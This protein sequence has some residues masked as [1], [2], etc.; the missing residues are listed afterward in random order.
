MRLVLL[1]LILCT[2][3]KVGPAYHPPSVETPESW[4]T[5][6]AALAPIPPLGEWWDLF[7]DP[8][9]SQLEEQAVKNNPDLNIALYRIEE[10]QAVASLV[11]S[12][13][14]PSIDLLPGFTNTGTLFKIF[15][16]GTLPQGLIAKDIYRIHQQQFAFPLSLNYDLDLFGRNQ[17]RYES[18]FI[19]EQAK[20]QAYRSALLD[21]TTALAA[22]YFNLRSIDSS[23]DL[24]EK[25]IKLREQDLKL[26]ERRFTGGLVTALDVE[27]YRQLLL[28]SKI[29]LVEN[30]RLRALQENQIAAY[31]GVPASLFCLP[32]HPL[33]E[34]PPLIP[35]GIP[36][37]MLLNRPD[38]AQAEREMASEHALV[39]AAYASFF[40][41]FSL[42]AGLGYVSPDFKA[43]MEDASR[44]WTLGVQADQT[45]FDG[46][47]KFSNLDISW[48]RFFEASWNYQSVAIRAFREVEDSLMDLDAERRQMENLKALRDAAKKASALSKRRYDQ[49]LVNNFEYVTNERTVL[50]A[51]LRLSSLLGLQYSSTAKLIRSIGGLP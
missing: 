38:L 24:L 10:A 5:P 23:I 36:C 14:F 18:A 13:L 44:F 30:Q 25:T 43:F 32:F 28:Q 16:P 7:E 15:L 31:M 20:E 48:A 2:Q 3:C 26:S 39:G 40:P 47:R 45:L 1:I 51:E 17:Q 35:A 8:T 9:L 6:D 34:E 49:G 50:D 21:L 22:A 41:S 27:N 42:T 46:G 4:K 11:K 33:Y 12:D 29:D 19:A 37:E